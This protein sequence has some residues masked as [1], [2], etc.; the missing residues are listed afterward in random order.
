MIRRLALPIAAATLAVLLALL[1]VLQYRWLGQVSDGERQRMRATLEARASDFAAAFDRELG[2]VASTFSMP[3]AEVAGDPSAGLAARWDHWQ[4]SASEP[5]LVR[6]LLVVDRTR[7]Q[8]TL[9]RFDL[10]TRA[11]V[12][13]D[14]PD[15]FRA[16]RDRWAAEPA[17]SNQVFG[18]VQQAPNPH[19]AVGQLRSGTVAQGPDALAQLPRLQAR[20]FADDLSDVP[21]IVVPNQPE[22]L[23]FDNGAMPTTPAAAGGQA[24]P[25]TGDTSAPKPDAGGTAS[26]TAKRLVLQQS[27][28]SPVVVAWLDLDEIRRVL[29]PSLVKR[30]FA[31]D[32]VFDYQVSVILRRDPKTVLFESDR[33]PGAAAASKDAARPQGDA[34]APMFR[35]RLP[36]V[37]GA[38]VPDS[39]SKSYSINITRFEAATQSSPR[40]TV[41]MLSDSSGGWILR[42]VHRAGSLDAAVNRLRRRN[43][44]ISSSILG[45]LALSLGF[46]LVSTRRAQRL[47]AQQVEF[48]ASVSHELRTPLSVIRSAGE[49]LAD[50]VV[51]SPEHVR[52]YG[53]LVAEEGRKLGA[54]VEQ[55]MEYAGMQSDEPRWRKEPV[56]LRAVVDDAVAGA[57]RVPEARTAAVDVQCDDGLPVAV[58]DRAALVRAV[59]NLVENAIKYGC[60]NGRAEGDGESRVAVRVSAERGPGG[61]GTSVVIEVSDHGPGI[62][63]RERRRI[64]EPFVRGRAAAHSGV[65]GNGLGLSIVRRIVES[66]G[67]KVEVRGNAAGGATFRI[68]LIATPTFHLPQATT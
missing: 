37:L 26:F 40:N 63:A 51:D 15:A 9:R 68:V 19:V 28:T 13:A 23:R 11:L 27:S 54:M 48:V 2:T 47:A 17:S 59:Q 22:V 33:T 21:A 61:T 46:V 41:V 12:A 55:V 49:N 25:A 57:R 50:G 30:Y 65:P 7:P 6:E 35:M 34:V 1:A 36:D 52:R 5:K 62:E 67:G 56:D 8:P 44:A 10:S 39:A 29:L 32:D 38:R 14:W 4:S 42:L 60:A 18:F 45:L 58:A 31:A 64:F 20:L 43:L 3:A 24:Q 53:A 16:A 66:H